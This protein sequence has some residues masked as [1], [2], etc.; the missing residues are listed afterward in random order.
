MSKQAKLPL[1]LNIPD[2]VNST[3]YTGKSDITKTTAKRKYKI[4]LLTPSPSQLFITKPELDSEPLT[5]APG[6]RPMR[7]SSSLKHLSIN[8]SLPKLDL[9]RNSHGSVRRSINMMSHRRSM[10]QKVTKEDDSHE[11]L[12]KIHDKTDRETHSYA[13][14]DPKKTVG[15]D[16]VTNFYSHYKKLDKIIDQNE[17]KDIK[18]TIYTTFLRNEEALGLFP[19]KIG[20]IKDRGEKSHILIKY[21]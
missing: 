20:M 14:K 11:Y 6:K 9:P 19:S 2:S 17:S 12:K 21:I 4:G 1:Q 13:D 3:F 8:S 18:D 15:F 7:N 10:S 5:F 16:A